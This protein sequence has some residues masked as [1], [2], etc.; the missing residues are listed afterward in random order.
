MFRESSEPPSWSNMHINN[1]QNNYEDPANINNAAVNDHLDAVKRKLEMR[2]K[3]IESEKRKSFISPSNSSLP[4]MDSMEPHSG[5]VLSREKGTLDW[6]LKGYTLA[7][8]QNTAAPLTS[9]ANSVAS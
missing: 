1:N 7:D 2:R 8:K 3:R 9:P 4:S 5:E 6:K